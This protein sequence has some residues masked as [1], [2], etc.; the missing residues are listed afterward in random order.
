MF[1]K[2]AFFGLLGGLAI[3]ATISMPASAESGSVLQSVLSNG[4]LRIAVLGSLP[5]YSTV[6]ADG[7][8]VGYDIDIAKKL[9]AA[10][11]VE[12]EF[13][14]TDI[15]SRVTSL[16]TGKVDVTIADFTRNV[17]RSTS[18]AFSNPYV[19]TNMR[20]LVPES[21]TYKTIEEANAAKIRVAISRGGTAERAVPAH[22]PNAQ[23]VRFNTQADELSALLSGQVD[24]MAEDDFYNRKAISDNAG[25]LRQVDGSLA[26]A[27]IAIGVPAGDA[28]WLRVV[29]LFVDQF[30]ASGDNK[31]LFN[32]WFGFDQ[33]ALQAQY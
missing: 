28:D 4:K 6:G 12:P 8:P 16:Q 21:A 22:L 15:P 7:V 11:K 14:V 32:K 1:L 3:A 19:V 17:E 33:P 29:N 10:L 27:E 18:V 2:R 23:I 30:N 31:A 13:V 24:A 25:K 26:R 20:L 5:P 9:A